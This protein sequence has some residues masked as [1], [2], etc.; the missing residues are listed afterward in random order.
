MRFEPWSTGSHILGSVESSPQMHSALL[1]RLP[2]GPRS[3]MESLAP[4]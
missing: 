3:P 4:G 2:A 1:H